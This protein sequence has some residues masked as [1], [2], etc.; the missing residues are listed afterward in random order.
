MPSETH[1]QL[2]LARA[3]RSVSEQGRDLVM[4]FP[5]SR[6]TRFYTTPR[7][8]LIW[9]ALVGFFVGSA[10]CPFNPP[11]PDGQKSMNT[12]E[13]LTNPSNDNINKERIMSAIGA[14]SPEIETATFALG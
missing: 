9:L 6:F 13:T 12:E 14:K 7:N 4:D 5:E 3:K 1:L 10:I 2:G 11:A 8:R